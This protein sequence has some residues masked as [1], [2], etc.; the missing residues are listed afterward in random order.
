MIKKVLTVAGSDSSGGAGIQADLKT[1]EEYGTFGFSALTSIVTM[2]PDEDW[3][4]TVTPIEPVLVEKQLKTIF[5]GGALDAMKT[6][7]LGTI[8]AIEITR[9]YIDKFEMNNI[10]IDPV[11]ACKGTSELLQPENV[12][13]MTRLLLPKATI[14][15]PN[16]V[17]AGIL[18]GMGDLTSV[19]QMKEAA[20]NII[21]LGPKSVV[22][23][24]GHRLKA[25]KAIDLFYDGTD[26]TI[27][28]EKL[29]ATDYNHGAGCTFA[30]AV[31]AGF[32]KGYSVVDSVSLAKKFVAAAIKNGQ[33]INPFLGH[34]WHGAYNHAQDRMTDN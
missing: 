13:A 18:S 28:E 27:F 23:K 10:V 14:T 9:A 5:A 3:S 26:F 25:D 4:H 15:T 29:F 17:E 31:T 30:A 22:I 32:A 11:M 34:V 8:E 1:F 20:K 2:D 24:G 19:E 6:G 21:D 12:A 16:L 33:K 7:M